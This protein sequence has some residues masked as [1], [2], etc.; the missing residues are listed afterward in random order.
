MFSV[1]SF[2]YTFVYVSCATADVPERVEGNGETVL[3]RT[4]PEIANNHRTT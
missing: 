1:T 2:R 3:R 4:R